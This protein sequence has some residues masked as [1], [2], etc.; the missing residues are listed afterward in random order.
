MTTKKY[1]PKQ[2]ALRKKLLAKVH[3]TAIYKDYFAHYK[4][5]YKKM[6][7]GSFSKESAA[8]LSIPQLLILVDYLTLKSNETSN[9][10]AS[11]TQN[12]TENSNVIALASSKSQNQS[13]NQNRSPGINNITLVEPISTAQIN[14]IN[15]LW[16]EK[17]R[18]P[19]TKAL[20][21]FIERNFKKIILNLNALTKKEASGLINALNHM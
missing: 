1:T 12:N 7:K 21:T 17:A 10:Q 11:S 20:H 5:E 4:G 18:T 8:D 14:Y 6:L 3:L 2:Q 15:T 9:T 13:Q 19:T 16:Q